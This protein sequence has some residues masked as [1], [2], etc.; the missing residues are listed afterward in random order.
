LR[1]ALPARPSPGDPHH[2]PARAPVWRGPAD[3]PR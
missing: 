2:Q 3:A 1:F